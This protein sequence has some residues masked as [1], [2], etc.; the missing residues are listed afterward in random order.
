M[1]NSK[2]FELG[3]WIFEIN[4][5]DV[6]K[7]T[8]ILPEI[9][10]ILSKPLEEAKE[11]FANYNLEENVDKKV[12]FDLIPAITAIF[13][14]YLKPAEIPLFLK[15]VLSEVR[16]KKKDSKGSFID[17]M[18]VYNEVFRGRITDQFVLAKEVLFFNFESEF[19]R[20]FESLLGSTGA[21]E[22]VKTSQTIST[23]ATM[24]A[25]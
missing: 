20:F 22:E 7:A 14:G 1:R 3:E 12:F 16:C 2:T 25:R 15:R 4:F 10:C 24:K 13:N 23:P 8:V 6:E 18:P 21:A 9:L 11:K 19:Q 17:I 5:F